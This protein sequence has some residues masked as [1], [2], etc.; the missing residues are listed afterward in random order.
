MPDQKPY[1]LGMALSGGGTRGLAHVGVLEVLA[2]VGLVPDLISGVSAGAIVGT[3]YQSGMNP[4]QILTFFHSVDL[5]DAKHLTFNSMGFIN[6]MSFHDEIVGYFQENELG[7]LKRPMIIGTTNLNTGKGE[8][9]RQGEIVRPMLASA[10]VP[11]LFKPVRINGDLHAD[12]GIYSN[13][14]ARVIRD[15]CEFVIGV[16]VHPYPIGSL[17]DSEMKSPFRVLG[18]SYEIGRSVALEAEFAVCDIEL[19]TQDIESFGIFDMDGMRDIYELGKKTARA[20]L[21]DI[22]QQVGHLAS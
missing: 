8:T 3:L 19:I 12:G 22:Q 7:K 21:A 15:L 18:R 11:G 9:F 6:P 17:E 16:Y 5:F 20:A 2:E 10:S 4:D 13:L 14:P 1:K